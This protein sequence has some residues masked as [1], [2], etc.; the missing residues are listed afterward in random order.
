ME[1]IVTA[2]TIDEL[3]KVLESSSSSFTL[4][5]SKV[6][7][8]ETFSFSYEVKDRFNNSHNVII[9]GTLKE[10]HADSGKVTELIINQVD[11]DVLKM[12]RTIF[13]TLAYSILF[14]VYVILIVRRPTEYWSYFLFV[15]FSILPYLGLKLYVFFATDLPS[16]MMELSN[17]EHK[18]KK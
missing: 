1:K 14:A 6:L 5:E 10:I 2:Y 12:V 7:K 16:T 13:L 9:E 18:I 15:P 8:S 17:F 11:A 4:K 3:K